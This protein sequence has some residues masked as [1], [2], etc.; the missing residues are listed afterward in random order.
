MLLPRFTIRTLLV[1]L[2]ICALVFVIF[3]MAYRG[4]HWALGITIA[5]ASL[6]FTALVHAAWFGVVWLVARRPSET[7][8]QETGNVYLRDDSL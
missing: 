5:L 2:T 3:G 6:A 7:A 8:N 1:M 4:K